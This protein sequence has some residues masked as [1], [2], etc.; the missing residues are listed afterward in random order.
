[1]APSLDFGPMGAFVFCTA[2]AHARVEEGCAMKTLGKDATPGDG[3]APIPQDAAARN[4]PQEKEGDF[5][6]RAIERRR[7][8]PHLGLGP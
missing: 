4:R 7:R 3:D 1:M 6:G 2:Q 8:G 5:S